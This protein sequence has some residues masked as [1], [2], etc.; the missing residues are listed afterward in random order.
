MK[1]SPL[2]KSKKKL[3]K[4]SPLSALK[5]KAWEV[6]S[7]WIRKRDKWKCITCGIII[8]GRQMHAGHFRH[9]D[10]MDFVETNVN[11]QCSR[12]NK[13]LHGN[14]GIYAIELDKKYGAGTAAGLVELSRK[15]RGYRRQDYEDI[16]KRYQIPT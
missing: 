13:W 10:W 7:L 12:C 11:S 4:L 1:R 6:F 8:I 16:I 14:L 5:R 3:R 9:G 15:H 2:K